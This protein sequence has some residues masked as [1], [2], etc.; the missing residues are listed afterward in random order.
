MLL[1]NSDH[2]TYEVLVRDRG[3]DGWATCDVERAALEAVVFLGA[4]P[5]LPRRSVLSSEE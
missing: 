4:S 1:I 3:L 2:G 5:V